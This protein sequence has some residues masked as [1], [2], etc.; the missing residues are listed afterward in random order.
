MP[1]NWNLPSAV[2]TVFATVSPDGPCSTTVAF[3]SGCMSASS[4]TPAMLAVTSARA[5]VVRV[6]TASATRP[7]VESSDM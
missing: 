5:A 6:K 4:T 7:L 3:A 2:V 1:V